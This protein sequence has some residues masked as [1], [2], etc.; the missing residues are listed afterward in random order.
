V[1]KQPHFIALYDKLCALSSH[2]LFEILPGDIAIRQWHRRT[3]AGLSG[4]QVAQIAFRRRTKS[5]PT[6]GRQCICT[7]Q[8]FVIEPGGCSRFA[9][10]E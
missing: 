3:L 1:L 2:T 6:A 9:L 8:N 4:G 10:F 7:S 5:V